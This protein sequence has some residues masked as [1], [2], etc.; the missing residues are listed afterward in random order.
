M[1]RHTASSHYD[2]LYARGGFGYEARR[3]RWRA[4]VRRHYV[5]AFGLSPRDRLLDIPCGDGFWTSVF[6]ELGM[7]ARGVDLS[8]GGVEAARRKYAGLE[9]SVG[10][11]EQDL[12]FAKRSFDV[13]FS[14]GITHLHRP[15]L[16]TDASFRM[17]RNLMRYV[18]PGGLLLVSYY[19]KRD[20]SQ[21]A[22][23]AQHPVSDLV[24]LLES[25]GDVFKVDVVD[26]FV[27][28]GVR[29]LGAPSEHPRVRTYPALVRRVGKAVVARLRQVAKRPLRAGSR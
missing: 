2:R 14:R 12:P 21:P 29:P 19:T 7:D 16:F 20:G 22:R 28:I 17:A 25:A 1:Q 9:F 18:R 27:Q 4:W 3:R 10:D 26:D 15:D 23:H 5:D 13:V 11:A 6:A 24:R 8:A